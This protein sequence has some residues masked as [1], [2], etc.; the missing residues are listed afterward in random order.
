MLT[1][2]VFVPLEA[3]VYPQIQFALMISLSGL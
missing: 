1:Q 2:S 3:L